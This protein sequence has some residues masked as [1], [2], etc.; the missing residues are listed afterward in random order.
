MAPRTH[1][2][3]SK[4]KHRNESFLNLSIE[5]VELDMERFQREG[6]HS[7]RELKS[8]SAL[9]SS[10]VDRIGLL[11]NVGVDLDVCGVHGAN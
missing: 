9:N 4:E 3:H 10:E 6:G 8:I 1:H 5:A 11:D 7:D 2:W